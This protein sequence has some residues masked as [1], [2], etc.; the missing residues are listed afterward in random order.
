A[1]SPPFA[2]AAASCACAAASAASAS[3]TLPCTR[4]TGRR[5]SAL[6]GPANV[7]ASA[8]LSGRACVVVALAT[9]ASAVVAASALARGLDF[10]M[11]ALLIVQSDVRQGQP[12][13]A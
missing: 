3:A 6:A 5:A 2:C 10:F 12:Q 13:V 4:R 1:T 9:R 11:G 8:P 7:F